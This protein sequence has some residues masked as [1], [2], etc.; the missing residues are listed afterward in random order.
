MSRVLHAALPAFPGV[1]ELRLY[2]VLDG[3]IDISPAAVLPELQEIFL[4]YVHP[5]PGH[6]LPPHIKLTHY[7]RPRT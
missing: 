7:P 3:P 4:S 5:E 6:S 1:R 2:G